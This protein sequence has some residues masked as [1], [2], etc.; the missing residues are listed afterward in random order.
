ME[1]GTSVNRIPSPILSLWLRRDAMIVF[2]PLTV[3]L[4]IR[5]SISWATTIH[6]WNLTGQ[7]APALSPKFIVNLRRMS[8]AFS[9]VSVHLVKA[10]DATLIL[11]KFKMNFGDNA[12]AF[13]PV[14]FQQG[15]V[16]S[17]I[18]LVPIRRDTVNGTNTI[19]VPLQRHKNHQCSKYAAYARTIFHTH[20]HGLDGSF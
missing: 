20:S 17:Q 9:T 2:V 5:T 16:I 12:G 11:L 3:R 14:R 13:L 18:T 1:A 15:I 6:C 10:L 19:I 4:L 8:V 7:N